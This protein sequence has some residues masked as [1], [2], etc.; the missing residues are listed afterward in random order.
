MHE[1]WVLGIG[2]Y[3]NLSA[4]QRHGMPV[5]VTAL[6]KSPEFFVCEVGMCK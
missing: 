2:P 5:S 3:D 1:L 6:E 4:I